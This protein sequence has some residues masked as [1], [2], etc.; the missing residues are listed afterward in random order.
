M[1]SRTAGAGRH[2]EPHGVGGLGGSPCRHAMARP[3]PHGTWRVGRSRLPRR[4]RLCHETKFGRRPPADGHRGRKGMDGRM[5]DRTRTGRFRPRLRGSAGRVLRRASG[6]PVAVRGRKSGICLQR[7]G[8]SGRGAGPHRHGLR[9]HDYFVGGFHPHAKTRSVGLRLYSP[10][11][12][13]N[14]FLSVRPM[15]VPPVGYGMGGLR[16]KPA[17]RNRHGDRLVEKGRRSRR[18]RIVGRAC[19]MVDGR[20][21][22]TGGSLQG[23]PC[24]LQHTGCRLRG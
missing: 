8:R 14:V 19:R 13:L 18:G 7:S 2:M 23:I 21:K 6:F 1:G 11:R 24:P 20:N 10:A 4:M 15:A 9:A 16:R 12:G 5:A 3:P 17:G 22:D